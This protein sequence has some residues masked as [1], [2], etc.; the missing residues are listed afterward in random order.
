MKTYVVYRCLYGETF[1]QPSIRSIEGVAD[2][3]FVFWDDTAWA[4]CDH[5]VYKG[6]RV[7]FPKPPATFDGVVNR[8]KEL[9]CPKV[10][11]AYDH[12][13]NNLNQFTHFVND[14]ILPKYP[15]PDLFIFM[16]VDYVFREDQL[17]LALQEAQQVTHCS[18]RQVEV[19]KGLKHR[20]PERTERSGAMFWNMRHLDQL[21][22]TGRGGDASRKSTQAF[23][24][25]MGFAFGDTTMYWKHMTALAFS[26]KIGDA[27]PNEG[28]YDK[29]LHWTP[30][31]RDLEIS[32]GSEHNIPYVIPYPESELP[33]WLKA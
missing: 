25:N 24:H 30:E 28:W 27:Q 1:I 31:T 9:Q 26:R 11:L 6:Q 22:P 5:V 29:W 7:D 13:Y 32:E 23:I 17:A 3:I 2:Q 16:E 14:L 18:T 10:V 21:P 15:K 33:H 8:I 4:D 19:W 12:Q 20:V